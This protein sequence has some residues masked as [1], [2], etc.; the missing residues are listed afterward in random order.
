MD[1]EIKAQWVAA[2]RSGKYEQGREQL[3]CNDKFCCLGVLCDLVKDDIGAAWE[4]DYFVFDDRRIGALLP[5]K[6][7]IHVGLLNSTITNALMGMN[8]SDGASFKDIANFIER[9][10]NL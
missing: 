6:V 5:S 1:A 10:P 8:D 3:R 4:A 2:L 7:R 9:H